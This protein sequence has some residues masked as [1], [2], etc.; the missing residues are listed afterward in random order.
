MSQFTQNDNEKIDLAIRLINRVFSMLNVPLPVATLALTELLLISNSC[1]AEDMKSLKS[2]SDYWYDNIY[3]EY[4][5]SEGQR[6]ID[7]FNKRKEERKAA[8]TADDTKH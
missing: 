3:L 7:F 2:K 5:Y 8:K 4:M 6:Q 1:N